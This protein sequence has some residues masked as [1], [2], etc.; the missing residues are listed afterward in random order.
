MSLVSF[1]LF[2][3]TCCCLLIPETQIVGEKVAIALSKGLNVIACIGET[4]EERKAEKT[5]EVCTRQMKA[6]GG[7]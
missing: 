1:L 3:S 5:L 4:L 2:E 6:I 7:T